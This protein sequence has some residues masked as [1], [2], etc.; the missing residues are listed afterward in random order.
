MSRVSAMHLQAK[1]CGG[2]APSAGTAAEQARSRRHSL[3]WNRLKSH[4]GDTN[5]ATVWHFAR[6]LV[7]RALPASL[8][9]A[10]KCKCY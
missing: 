8:G 4:L 2:D 10:A 6:N 7:A 3:L 5:V 1:S 9:A